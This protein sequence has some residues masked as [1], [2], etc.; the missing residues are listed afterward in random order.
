MHIAGKMLLTQIYVPD[1]DGAKNAY[2]TGTDR[3]NG[4]VI[5][6]SMPIS[7]LGDIKP[8]LDYQFEAVVRGGVSAKGG[9]YLGCEK[10]VLKSI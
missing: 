2:L 3:E 6:M 5:K 1:G 9:Y 4:G 8:L 7:N 10:I